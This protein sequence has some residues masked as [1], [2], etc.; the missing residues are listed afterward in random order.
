M[1]EQCSDVREEGF[2]IQGV[3]NTPC[4]P[5]EWTNILCLSACCLAETAAWAGQWAYIVRMGLLVI[6][7]EHQ[8]GCPRA[9]PSGHPRDSASAMS[10]LVRQV[11]CQLP[12][13]CYEC[14]PDPVHRRQRH[15]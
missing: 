7:V 14:M 12:S 2:V 15:S 6:R 8:I 3:T 10:A 1:H 4:I 5:H 11:N 9:I 13:A